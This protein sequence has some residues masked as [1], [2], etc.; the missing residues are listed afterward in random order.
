[1]E[2]ATV[3]APNKKMAKI[4]ISAIPMLPTIHRN[5]VHFAAVSK[6]AFA[7][8]F[9]LNPV[10]SGILISSSIVVFL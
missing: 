4:T 10:V 8:S 6:S 9:T 2:D 7:L 5:F 1:M 3:P